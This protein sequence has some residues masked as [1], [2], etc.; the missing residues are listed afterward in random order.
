MDIIVDSA[1]TLDEALESKDIPRAIRDSLKLVDVDYVSFDGRPHRGQI[2]IAAEV[3]K[4]I[5][6]I[7]S[8]LF[9]AKFPIQKAVP[10]C[11]YGWDDERSMRD[12]NTSAFNY[13]F[14]AGTQ[15]L[16]NH[17]RG[18]AIDIN[19]LLNPYEQFDGATVPAG[20]V[21]DPCR[22]GTLTKDSL[23]V[24]L[25]LERGWDWGGLWESNTDWQH[26]AR[27]PR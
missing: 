21:Y 13:R 8:L 5:R 16:S 23:P 9:S 4:D 27:A 17:A 3:E 6:E 22:P 25:F 26:F 18:V 14:I 1:L 2:L 24:E 11:A 19:P 7:F 15:R 20:A 12:N 10:V